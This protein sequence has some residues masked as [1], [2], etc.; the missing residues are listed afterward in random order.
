MLKKAIP[1]IFIFLLTLLSAAYS[2][3]ADHIIAVKV[4]GTI[5]AMSSEVIDEALREAEALNTPLIILIDTPGGNLDATIKI[6]DR[7]ERSTVPV[8]GYVYPKGARAWSAGTYILLSTHIASMA[9]H[10]ILGSAQP[11]AY[12]PLGGTQPI[13]DTKTINALTTFLVEKARMHGRNE[14]TAARFIKENLNLSA[15]EAKKMGVIEY[16]ADS[17]EELLRMIDGVKVELLEGEYI[18]KTEGLKIVWW[19]PSLRLQILKVLSDPIISYI[20]FIAGLYALIFGLTSPGYGSEVIG[21]IC[22]IL[23]LIGLGL[24][25]I[26]IG[27]ILLIALGAVLLLAELFT[28]GFG[29]LGGA[30]FAC[31]IIGGILLFPTLPTGPWLVSTDLLNQL[32]L[33]TLLA[34]LIIGAFFIFAAYKVIQARKRPPAIGDIVGGVC[35][36]VEDIPKGKIGLVRCGAEYWQATSDQDITKGQ[37][38]KVIQKDG[39]ILKIEPYQQT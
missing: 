21:G 28:P 9:P 14:T 15:E 2:A 31:I 30:G 33:I 6:I 16:V 27:G 4:D 5:T 25:G 29:L 23:G 20:L 32:L 37:K 8:I 24:T 34:P 12:N 11:V 17:V 22:L 1:L 35:V 26:F 3:K 7:I 10:T 18:I 36:A 38:V 19:E 39:P 13:N